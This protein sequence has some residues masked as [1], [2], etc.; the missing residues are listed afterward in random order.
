M[1][2]NSS[3]SA[4]P[5]KGVEHLNSMIKAVNAEIM[6]DKAKPYPVI[7]KTGNIIIAHNKS[8]IPLA[9]KGR[10]AQIK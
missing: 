3:T 1:R 5:S 8:G 10:L 2:N 4:P 9:N 6:T 7:K